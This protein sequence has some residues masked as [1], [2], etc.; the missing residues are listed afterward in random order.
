MDGRIRRFYTGHQF[1]RNTAE[2]RHNLDAILDQ[3]E[4]LP[5]LC[6]RLRCKLDL[7]ATRLQKKRGRIRHQILLNIHRAWSLGLPDHTRFIANSEKN[8][9]QKSWGFVCRNFPALGD[10]AITYQT[11]TQQIS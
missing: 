7:P 10:G 11:L 2:R 4:S 6:L 5:I 8:W 1:K 3:A 9:M